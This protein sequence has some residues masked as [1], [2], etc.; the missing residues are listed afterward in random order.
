MKNFSYRQAVILLLVVFACG[1]AAG[2]FAM[3]LYLAKSVTAAR[4][5]V[6][7]QWRERYVSDLRD[8]LHLND[9]QIQK[10]N[11]ILDSTKQKYDEVRARYKPEMDGIHNEQVS[12]IHAML[13]PEQSAEYDKF[14]A[15]RDRERQKQQNAAAGR[16]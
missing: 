4:P 7:Q 8:R 15:E 9:E 12:S 5:N 14:R 10:L 2:G 1:A 11:I 6:P 16:K 13:Q 3:S